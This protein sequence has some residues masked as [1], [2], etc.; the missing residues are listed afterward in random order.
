MLLRFAVQPSGTEHSI[1]KEVTLQA[2]EP[3]RGWEAEWVFE[4]GQNTP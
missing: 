2:K 4:L 3:D 1:Q